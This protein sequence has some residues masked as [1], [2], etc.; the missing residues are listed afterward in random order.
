MN[1]KCSIFNQPKTFF[2]DKTD[3]YSLNII[4][5]SKCNVFSSV[6][7]AVFIYLCYL[8]QRFKKKVNKERAPNRVAGGF[9][10]N[11]LVI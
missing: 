11:H 1:E 4:V 3:F 9:F 5:T 10:A 6:K 8:F 7:C 2:N